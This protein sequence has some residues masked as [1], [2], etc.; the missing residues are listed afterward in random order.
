MMIL[1]ELVKTAPQ[2]FAALNTQLKLGGVAGSLSALN[3]RKSALVIFDLP[4][5]EIA[6]L[7]IV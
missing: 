4:S 5:N 7:E 1:E 6:E 2:I 3:Q